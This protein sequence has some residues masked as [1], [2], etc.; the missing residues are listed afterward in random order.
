[1]I[2]ETESIDCLLLAGTAS[3]LGNHLG[4][5]F[6]LGLDRTGSRS[7]AR[8]FLLNSIWICGRSHLVPLTAPSLLGSIQGR[9]LLLAVPSLSEFISHVD[10]EY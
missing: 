10:E 2:A 7:L 5:P 8:A 9:K 1:M 6:H 4:G 3:N